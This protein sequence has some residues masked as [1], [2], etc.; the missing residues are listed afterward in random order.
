MSGVQWSVRRNARF[1][2]LRLGYDFR[3]QRPC[4]PQ[5]TRFF[6]KPYRSGAVG[7][8]ACLKPPRRPGL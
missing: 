6:L 4:I 5:D 7:D 8:G 3:K 1:L 2:T